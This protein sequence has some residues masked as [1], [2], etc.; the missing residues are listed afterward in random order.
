MTTETVEANKALIRR[1]SEEVTN[2]KNYDLLDEIVATDATFHGFPGAEGELTGPDA[3]EE[4]ARQMHEAFPDLTADI[5]AVIAEGDLLSTRTVM[6]GTHE[7]EL[8][9]IPPTG[10]QVSVDVMTHI[11]VEDGLITEVW[12]QVDQFG[13]MQQL[14]V[15]EAPGQ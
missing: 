2:G 14:G 5:K 3:Y 12:G 9:D 6:T 8:F 1:L 15:I 13:L 10:K 4:Q 11:R 7:G